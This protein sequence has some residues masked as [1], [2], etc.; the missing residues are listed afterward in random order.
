VT[1]MTKDM[2]LKMA[3]WHHDRMENF[4]VRRSGRTISQ[5]T[6]SILDAAV[7]HHESAVQHIKCSKA[8][9]SSLLVSDGTPP[10]VK[11]Q[12]A[13]VLASWNQ[14]DGPMN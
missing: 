5:Y 3:K 1:K 10:D 8:L 4:G 13:H 14:A 9:I 2:Q 11:E 6:K 12:L 7:A